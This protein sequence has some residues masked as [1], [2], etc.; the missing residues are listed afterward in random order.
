LV[1]FQKG[2]YGFE[3]ELPALSL[4]ADTY[5]VTIIGAYMGGNSGPLFKQNIENIALSIDENKTNTEYL[6]YAKKRGGKI[7][8]PGKWNI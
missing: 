1:S 7:I 4:I 3:Y 5:Y 8:S 2:K 6:G